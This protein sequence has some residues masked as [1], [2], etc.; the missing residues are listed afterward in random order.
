MVLIVLPKTNIN[1]VGWSLTESTPAPTHTWD[2]R[3][4]YLIRYTRGLSAPTWQFWFDLEVRNCEKLKYDTK[5]W[6]LTAV[7]IVS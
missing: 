5:L 3:P 7:R 2:D 1:L 6:L 4:S